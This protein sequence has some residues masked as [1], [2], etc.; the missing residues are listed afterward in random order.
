MWL[1]CKINKPWEEGL[2]HMLLPYMD[3]YKLTIGRLLNAPTVNHYKNKSVNHTGGCEFILKGSMLLFSRVRVLPL[4]N[5]YGDTGISRGIELHVSQDFIS[6]DIMAI[7]YFTWNQKG[8]LF[9]LFQFSC[10]LKVLFYAWSVK[11]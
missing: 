10:H 9:H 4:A 1:F 3:C 11:W 8:S 5:W 6:T 7:P 2:V